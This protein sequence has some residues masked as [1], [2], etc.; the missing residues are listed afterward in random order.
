[1]TP[2]LN[3]LLQGNTTWKFEEQGVTINLSFHGYRNNSDDPYMNHPGIWCYY[4]IIPE[5]MYP[6]R[7]NEFEP[8]L[9]EYGYQH[10]TASFNHDQFDTEITFT[11]KESYFDRITN[12]TYSSVKVGC[13]YNHLWHSEQGYRDSFESVKRDAIL[14]VT[15]FLKDNPDYNVRCKYSGVWDSKEN[16]YLAFNGNYYHNSIENEI[17]EGWVGYKRANSETQQK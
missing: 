5:Q 2:T 16:F 17:P 4:I 3:E 8:I 11:S 12:K 1:M 6:H 9:L 7:W 13:D 15:K 14:T 10:N